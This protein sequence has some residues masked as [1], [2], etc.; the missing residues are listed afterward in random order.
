VTNFII[1]SNVKSILMKEKRNLKRYFML[2][3]FL[4]IKFYWL[5]L[6]FLSKIYLKTCNTDMP[7]LLV[8]LKQIYLFALHMFIF[9]ATCMIWICLSFSIYIALV[10]SIVIIHCNYYKMML[11]LFTWCKPNMEIKYCSLK[12]WRFSIFSPG[13]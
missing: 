13:A 6:V 8:Y 5:N 7:G 12:V 9:N 1:C 11:M 4:N 2:I 10:N 3:L